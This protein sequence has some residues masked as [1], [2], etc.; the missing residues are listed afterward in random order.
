VFEPG[1]RRGK[2]GGDRPADH[3][4]SE[5]DV[6]EPV[7]EQ[8]P[9]P[10]PRDS[11]Q[12]ADQP[13]QRP[14]ESL[15]SRPRQLE[16]APASREPDLLAPRDQLQGEQDR[17]QLKDMRR[18]AGRQRERRNAEQQHEHD[19]EALPTEEPDEVAEAGLVAAAEPELE[20]IADRGR[21]I[22][23]HDSPASRATPERARAPRR[24]PG[25]AAGRPGSLACGGRARRR[26]SRAASCGAGATRSDAL[27]VKQPRAPVGRDQS[28]GIGAARPVPA[29]RLCSVVM[30]HLALPWSRRRPRPAYAP[31]R[32]RAAVRPAPRAPAES[33][34]GA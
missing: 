5:H 25:H 27:G 9:Q 7:V 15:L 31:L 13:Q 17:Y 6:A 2:E 24:P 1:E 18:A 19:R 33:A 8:E 32:L 16:P 23:A 28:T 11:L 14:E 21:A 22:S 26:S 30:L 34:A 10:G 3:E 20:L 29:Q 12:E 4:R